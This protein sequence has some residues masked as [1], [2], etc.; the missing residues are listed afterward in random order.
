MVPGGEP[1]YGVKVGD[2][3]ILVKKIKTDHNLALELYQ[4]GN[5][6]AMYLAGLIADENLVTRKVLQDWAKKAY[7]YMLSEYTVPWL[8]A[9]SLEIK[10]DTS[11]VFLFIVFLCQHFIHF[12][13]FFPPAFNIPGMVAF[14]QSMVL[15]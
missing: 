5:S 8:A 6:D 11:L 1:F 15:F 14:M 7:W 10:P 3:K 13:D 4:T 12:T 2:L 9:E